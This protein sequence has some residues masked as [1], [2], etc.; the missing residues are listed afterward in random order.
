MLQLLLYSVFSYE[1]FIA[2]FIYT[3]YECKI[4]NN[5]VLYM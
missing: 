2:V 3:S 4:K 1:C 5:L